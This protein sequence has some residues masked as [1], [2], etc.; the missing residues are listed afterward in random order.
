MTGFGHLAA[1]GGTAGYIVAAGRE[2]RGSASLAE[3][4]L[5]H[6]A[7]PPRP[8]DPPVG[9]DA[10]RRVRPLLPLGTHERRLQHPAGAARPGFPFLT[11]PDAAQRDALT[12]LHGLPDGAR[13]DPL[14]QN[15]AT[16][17]RLGSGWD[18]VSPG[19][20]TGIRTPDLLHAISRQAV[21]QHLSSQVTVPER[22]RL[23]GQVR[24]GCC[25]FPLYESPL[26]HAVRHD[27]G[28]SR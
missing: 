1:G 11:K 24:T 28:R 22:A 27:G 9:G 4:G 5:S 21:H 13:T 19:G 7:E 6:E 23:S 14:L 26:L 20:A 17:G 8:F 18:D 16:N 15:V 3:L 10:G 2:P 25:T 12:R